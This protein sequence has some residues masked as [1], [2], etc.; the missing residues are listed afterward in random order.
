[1]SEAGVQ[2]GHYAGRGE[3]AGA[4]SGGE[5][6]GYGESVSGEAGDDDNHKRPN[7]ACRTASDTDDYD[8]GGAGEVD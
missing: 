8:A 4:E 5:D 2:S 1:M 7:P 6:A 3:A